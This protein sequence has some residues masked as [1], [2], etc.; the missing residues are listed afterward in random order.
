MNGGQLSGIPEAATE[1]YLERT[2]Q[3]CSPLG[4]ERVCAEI[5]YE[6]WYAGR[7]HRIW[8]ANKAII[9]LEQARKANLTRILHEP[10]TRMAN[11]ARPEEGARLNFAVAQEHPEGTQDQGKS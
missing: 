10:I 5:I 9:A 7:H 1:H 11:R 2:G 4:G 6:E 3:A 8:L